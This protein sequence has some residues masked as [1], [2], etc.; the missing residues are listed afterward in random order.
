MAKPDIRLMLD[1]GI[2]GAWSRGESLSL[3]AYID[4]VREHQD[5]LWFYINM[6]VIPGEFRK[7]R[8]A[9]QVEHSA[10]QG[11]KNL[12]RM[13]KRGLQP[14]PVFHQ[15][16]RFEWLLRMVEDGEPYIGL[17]SAKD[18]LPFH[19]RRW[20]D[21]CF[22]LLTDKDG[23]PLVKTHGFGVTSP[24]MLMRYPF[25]SADS[26]TWILGSGF[27]HIMI[28]RYEGDRPNWLTPPFYLVTSGVQHQT[29]KQANQF[30]GLVHSNQDVHQRAIQLFMQQELG[31]VSPAELRYS[32]ILRRQATVAYYQ[33]LMKAMKD[34]RFTERSR[35]LIHDKVTDRIRDLMHG[36]PPI[37][38][39]QLHIMFVIDLSRMTKQVLNTMNVTTRCCSYYTIKDM[40][41]KIL[42]EITTLG[43][44]PP[45]IRPKAG[46][47][48]SQ[49]YQN[50]RRLK[51]LQR[52]G[53][54][55]GPQDSTGETVNSRTG[56]QQS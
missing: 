15:G 7:A 45:P 29:S 1:S 16:E 38:I 36:R 13:K 41:P 24:N 19:Q 30:E 39:P 40:D 22:S 21:Q 53:E 11:Y 8:S 25:W 23:R 10:A 5:Y 46:H 12:L 14:M 6:D 42:R 28:P 44:A 17:S 27:G 32:T 18:Y 50:Y 4:Y 35:G 56:D 31:G 37:H 2:F 33:G 55:N 3:D 51:L 49:H 48:N 43:P 9:E 52:Y 47:Y 26:T 54:G 34:S 20:L